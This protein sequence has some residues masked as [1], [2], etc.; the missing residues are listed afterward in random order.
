MIKIELPLGWK[1]SALPA[2][3]NQDVKA[4]A[5]ILKAEEKNGTLQVSRTLRSDL[6]MVPKESYPALRQF[7]QVVRT[8]DEEQIILQPGS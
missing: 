3:Q 8:G 5:Y 2:A 7:F 1:V 6:Y 4:A